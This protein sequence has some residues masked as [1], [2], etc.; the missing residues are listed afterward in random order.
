MAGDAGAN[1]RSALRTASPAF[2][3]F[4]DINSERRSANRSMLSPLLFRGRTE[5]FA[6]GSMGVED[7]GSCIVS[8]SRGPSMSKLYPIGYVLRPIIWESG[9]GVKG[10]LYEDWGSIHFDV[11]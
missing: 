8:G 2:S 9:V 4:C 5:S 7:E 1:E 6:A 10:K 11:A 3:S